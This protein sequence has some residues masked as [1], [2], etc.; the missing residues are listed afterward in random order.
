MKSYQYYG[1]GSEVERSQE[2]SAVNKEATETQY[3]LR[4]LVLKLDQSR[5]HD[6]IGIHAR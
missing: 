3:A 4:R 5:V 2:K 1:A 6:W